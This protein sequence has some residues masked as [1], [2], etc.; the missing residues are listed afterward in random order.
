MTEDRLAV[1][2]SSAYPVWIEIQVR[3]RDLDA[4]GHVNNA[5]Y[6][7]YFELGR[8]AYFEAVGLTD[9]RSAGPLDARALFPFILA[10]VSCR[11]LKPIPL[12]AKVHLGIRTASVGRK[13]WVF[14]YLLADRP[15]GEEDAVLFAAG[16]SVQVAYDYDRA[17]SMPLPAELLDAMSR[18]EGRN[19]GEG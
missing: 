11:Y 7:T 14:E 5:V 15:P 19:L 17:E 2:D 4:M 10:E 12:G 18:L 6:L 8:Q 1:R 9:R 16:R 13:S 3:F